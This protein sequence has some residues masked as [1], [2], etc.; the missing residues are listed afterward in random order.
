MRLILILLFV[1]FVN[2]FNF[3]YFNYKTVLRK[4]ID[5]SIIN[6]IKINNVNF[7]RVREHPKYLILKYYYDALENNEQFTKKDNKLIINYDYPISVIDNS[8][9][10]NV[11][12]PKEILV[13]DNYGN[14]NNNNYD[15]YD[16]IRLNTKPILILYEKK[17]PN[18]SY[19]YKHLYLIHNRTSYISKYSLN[20]NNNIYK[21]EFN[22]NASEVSKY[23][24]N[25]SIDVK[26]N[27]KKENQLNMTKNY[28]Q[29]WVNY[30]I[31]NNNKYY[32]YKKFLLF[33]YYENR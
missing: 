3:H 1:L 9:I 11:I 7:M 2:S 33:N 18:A 23:E 22:I 29:D 16:M 13:E 15:I 20:Y 4:S 31:Y 8:E 32:F 25:W 12:N 27:Y 6:F 30:N 28:I 5:D 21:Y 26:F 24:T 14:S 19:S 17:K 10:I